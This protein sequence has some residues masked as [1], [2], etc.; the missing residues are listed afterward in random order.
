MGAE[1]ESLRAL[2]SQLRDD[3]GYR[4][5][6]QGMQLL[7]RHKP[8]VEALEPECGHSGTL[9]GIVAQWVDAGF[10]SP[11]LLGRLLSKFPARNRMGLP[12]GDYLHLRMAE[13]A[14]AMSQEDMEQAEGH[15]QFVRSL[16]REC[17]DAELFAIANFWMGR[18]LR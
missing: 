18:C 17:D 14:L 8:M 9:V 13:G 16:E 3:L 4:R 10:D 12:L 15:F 11:E 2:L 1:A 6:E 7:E 5:I